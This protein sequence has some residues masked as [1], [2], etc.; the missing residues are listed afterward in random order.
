MRLLDTFPTATP[1]EILNDI[2]IFI[3]IAG[4]VLLALFAI[5]TYRNVILL[6]RTIQTNIAPV[7]N[8]IALL[9]LAATIGTLFLALTQWIRPSA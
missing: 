8:F 1:F 9:F 6:N 2:F 7:I 4:I 3:I 5:V